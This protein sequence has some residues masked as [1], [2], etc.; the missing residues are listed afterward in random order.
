MSEPTGD[1]KPPCQNETFRA[2]TEIQLLRDANR[3]VIPE[4]IPVNFPRD[5]TLWVTDVEYKLEKYV[6]YLDGGVL[7][8]TSDFAADRLKYCK[9]NAPDN[10]ITVSGAGGFVVRRRRVLMLAWFAFAP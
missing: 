2:W 3:N 7:G 5:A 6:V 9:S 4:E 8:T 10:C 1:P